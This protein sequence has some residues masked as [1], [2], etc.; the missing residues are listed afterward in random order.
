MNGFYATSPGWS[1][2]DRQIL[3][4][5][6]Q[7][8]FATS[9]AADV[10]ELS[11]FYYSGSLAAVVPAA[12]R[13]ANQKT[14]LLDSNYF[15]VA[16]GYG[17]RALSWLLSRLT[18]RTRIVNNAPVTSI[19]LSGSEVIVATPAQ[20]YTADYVVCTVT[21]GNLKRNDITFNPALPASYVAAIGRMGW[22]DDGAFLFCSLVHA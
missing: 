14:P 15:Y 3:D 22:V 1:A 19:T 20:S 21:L 12:M 8:L 16:D 6:Y 17:T 5:Y 18:N 10:S 11:L 4:F 2:E 13:F 9:A 7:S